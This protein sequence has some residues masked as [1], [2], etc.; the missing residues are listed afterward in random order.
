MT[1][2]NEWKATC[3]KYGWTMEYKDHEQFTEFLGQV[4]EEY[5]ELLDEVGLSRQ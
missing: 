2:T 4:N 1:E 3:R 5:R